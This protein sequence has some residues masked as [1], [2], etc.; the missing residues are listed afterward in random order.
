MTKKRRN[1]KDIYIYMY[2]NINININNN[3]DNLREFGVHTTVISALPARE[4]AALTALRVRVT[5]GIRVQSARRFSR[6]YAS[7][8]LP[9]G[10]GAFF[11]KKR[12]PVREIRYPF[13]FFDPL[14]SESA[15]NA[16]KD[17]KCESN[18]DVSRF[19]TLPQKGAYFTR[20]VTKIGF[21]AFQSSFSLIFGPSKSGY[22]PR[23]DAFSQS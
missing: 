21:G 19:F 1:D 2:I 8:R 22:F 6:F 15:K 18:R 10:F 9:L 11:W 4:T 17:E 12:P 20:G 14:S 13:S 23:W 5:P 7:P 16:L 3:N